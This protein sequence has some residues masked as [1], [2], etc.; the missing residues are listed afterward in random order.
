MA[1]VITLLSVVACPIGMGLMIWLM[2]RSQTTQAMDNTSTRMSTPQPSRML[3]CINW[4]V[5]AALSWGA[6]LIWLVVPNVFWAALP[7]LV[8]AACP[9][10]MLLMM[11]SMG[12]KRAPLSAERETHPHGEA[13]RTALR[14]QQDAATDGKGE[15]IFAHTEQR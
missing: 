8:M 12:R 4:K 15:P 5:V 3:L 1:Y 6:F 7:F 14:A 13:H 10:S 9:L 11:R 2:M